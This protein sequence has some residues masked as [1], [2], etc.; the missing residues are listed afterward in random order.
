MDPKEMIGLLNE[1]LAQEHACI[2]RYLT[3]AAVVK[4]VFHEP[5]K[6]RLTE[7]ATDEQTHAGL[8]RDRIVGLGGIP[9]TEVREIKMATDIPQILAINIEEEKSAISMYQRIQSK[10]P[11]GEVL[12]RETVDQLI[13]DEQEH[14]Q[15]LRQL[16]N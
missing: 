2:I 4:G 1:A 5:V 7:I 15:E 12:L 11:D 13:R 14:L 8:I 9:T 6:A 10:I 3:H 16:T